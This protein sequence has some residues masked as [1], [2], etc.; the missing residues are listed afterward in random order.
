[1]KFPNTRT[2]R[3]ERLALKKLVNKNI[4]IVRALCAHL[5]DYILLYN[6]EN[7]LINVVFMEGLTVNERCR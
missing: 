5:N 4:T 1:M 7:S 6:N 2:I 3:C